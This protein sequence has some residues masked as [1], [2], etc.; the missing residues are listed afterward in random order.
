MPEEPEWDITIKSLL[1][2]CTL[3][4]SHPHCTDLTQDSTGLQVSNHSLKRK[5]LWGNFTLPFQ[6]K[7]KKK[8][9]WGKLYLWQ[10]NC[11]FSK[12]FLSVNWVDCH[13]NLALLIPCGKL[14]QSCWSLEYKRTPDSSGGIIIQHCT[15]IHS[16]NSGLQNFLQKFLCV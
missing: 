14:L 6:M 8:R 12:L 16:E 1:S 4:L 2:S 10:L 5:L 3:N 11:G 15:K 13:G 7:L 9:I